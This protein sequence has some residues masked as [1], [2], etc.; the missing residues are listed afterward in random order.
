MSDADRRRIRGALLCG[1]LYLMLPACTLDPNHLCGEHLV[2]YGDNVR[3]V[4]EEGTAYTPNDCVPCGTNEVPGANGCVCDVGFSRPNP[5][6]SCAETPSGLGLA[7][8]TAGAACADPVYSSCHVVSGTTGYCTN[9]GCS[10]SSDCQGGYACDTSAS[11]AY[12]RRPPV[13]AGL[14]CPNGAADCAGT[15]ATFCSTQ[16]PIVCVVQGCTLTPD[17]CF[18]G[19]ECCDFSSYANYGVPPTLCVPKGAGPT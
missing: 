13:G 11:P 1:L 4:C 14:P 6:A 15:E 2:I 19:Y 17:N 12:C 16:A 18:E 7:C 10:S 9:T 5:D 3:C 8:D